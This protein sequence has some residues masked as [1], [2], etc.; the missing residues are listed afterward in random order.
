[1]VDHR[2]VADVYHQRKQPAANVSV[3]ELPVETTMMAEPRIKGRG[4]CVFSQHQTP[5]AEGGHRKVYDR[6]N[7]AS[8]K[9]TPDGY[10]LSIFCF[11]FFLYLESNGEDNIRAARAHLITHKY[12]FF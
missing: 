1:M 8:R 11:S 7:K 4:P 6:V 5:E 10:Y 12:S 3:S 9:N 2:D